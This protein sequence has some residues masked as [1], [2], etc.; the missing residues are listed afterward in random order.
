[1]SNDSSIPDPIRGFVPRQNPPRAAPTVSI[2]ASPDLSMVNTMTKDELISI[3]KTICGARWG[4]IA[5]MTKDERMEAAK[6]KL[7]HGG[8]TEKEIS[9]ALPALN[10]AMDREVGKPMQHVKADVEQKTTVTI[11][12][13]RKAAEEEAEALLSKVAGI[14]YR[15]H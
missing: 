15:N 2:E 8:L 5:L 1:M 7:W 9:K 6:L 14:E 12:D 10:A 4:E 11:E 13:R 3:I